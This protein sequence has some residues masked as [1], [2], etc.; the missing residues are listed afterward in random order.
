M[1]NEYMPHNGTAL[2]RIHFIVPFAM[3]LVYLTH[4]IGIVHSRSMASLCVNVWYCIRVGSR[5]IP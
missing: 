5:M 4:A 2:L 3:W 1:E